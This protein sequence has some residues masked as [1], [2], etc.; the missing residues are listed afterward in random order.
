MPDADIDRL[1]TEDAAPLLTQLHQRFG[2]ELVEGSG[3][4]LLERTSKQSSSSISNQWRFT[5]DRNA[6]I[7]PYRVWSVSGRWRQC[8]CQKCGKA[9]LEEA[10]HPAAEVVVGDRRQLLLEGQRADAIGPWRET[11]ASHRGSSL[12]GAVGILD[13][14]ER[15]FSCATSPGRN[16]CSER[17]RRAGDRPVLRRGRV[18]LGLV[19][20]RGLNR[21]RFQRLLISFRGRRRLPLPALIELVPEQVGL[22]QERDGQAEFGLVDRQRRAGRPSCWPRSA[23][24]T[25]AR[26]QSPT[27]QRLT[28]PCRVLPAGAAVL[29]PDAPAPSAACW[30]FLSWRLERAAAGPPGRS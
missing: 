26:R 23:P 16:A 30:C 3:R 6:W 28:A 27:P 15:A 25:P 21:L 8:S 24:A 17:A 12:T 1:G 18:L 22:A 29:P 2:D 10:E 19:V 14:D 5:S 20:I 13:G 9:L 7:A 4:L 11:R